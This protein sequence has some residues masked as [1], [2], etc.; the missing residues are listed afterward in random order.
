MQSSQQASSITQCTQAFSHQASTIYALCTC[1][2]SAS[3]QYSYVSSCNFHSKASSIRMFTLH[4]CNLWSACNLCSKQALS[5]HR[6]HVI[7]EQ[8]RSIYAV[9]YIHAI[10]TAWKQYTRRLTFPCLS[11]RPCKPL[12]S[13]RRWSDRLLAQ[14]LS[15]DPF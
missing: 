9:Q 13:S 11:T 4:I 15:L 6:T 14:L 8:A 2:H 5:I 10:F 7:V 1:N 12:R 3:M